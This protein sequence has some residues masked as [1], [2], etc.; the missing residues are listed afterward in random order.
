MIDE[1]LLVVAGKNV[2]AAGAVRPLDYPKAV[3]SRTWVAGEVTVDKDAGVAAIKDDSHS[4]AVP[5]DPRV[6]CGS[7]RLSGEGLAAQPLL[8]GLLEPFDLPAGLGW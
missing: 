8:Q 4:L 7:G 6:G 3:L 2:P 1:A 5:V